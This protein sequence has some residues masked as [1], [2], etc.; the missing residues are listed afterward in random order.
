[1]WG[2]TNAMTFSLGTKTVNANGTYTAADEGLAGY[3][4]IT[5]S[6]N[7]GMK[8]LM[9]PTVEIKENELRIGFENGLFAGSEVYVDGESVIKLKPGDD[10]VFLPVYTPKEEAEITVI[11]RGE[12]FEESEP[13]TVKY[14]FEEFERKKN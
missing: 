8:K 4:E 5:V 13:V 12:G 11:C 6:V 10:G 7:G 2:I 3:S 14:V 1:M 9:T